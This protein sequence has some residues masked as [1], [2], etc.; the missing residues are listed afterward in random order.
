LVCSHVAQG[1]LDVNSEEAVHGE[2]MIREDVT[3]NGTTVTNPLARVAIKLF[4]GT[5]MIGVGAL[6]FY[7]HY[8]TVS[9]IRAAR[10]W[11]EVPCVIEESEY[12]QGDEGD[13]FLQMTYR[14]EYDGQIYRSDRLDLL[15]GS[16]GDDG[17][18]EDELFETHPAGSES[19]CYVNPRDPNEAV[20]DR[21]HG[22]GGA[23]N[24]RL[25]SFPFLFA[26]GA[27]Y[28]S[29][30]LRWFRSRS[31]A[32]AGVAA[33][34]DP[35]D[36]PPPPRRAGLGMRLAIV[37]GAPGMT[38]LAWAFLVGFVFVFRIMEGP[39]MLR[40]LW[41]SGEFRTQGIVTKVT[42]LETYE[43]EQQ[44]YAFTFEYE[45]DGVSQRRE[46]HAR[47][48]RHDVGDRVE[49]VVDPE[50]PE[51][52]RIEGSRSREVPLWVAL[53]FGAPVPLLAFGVVAGYV[54][55]FRS[56]GL[57]RKG[58]LTHARRVSAASAP[59][60]D[61]A[62]PYANLPKFFFTVDGAQHRVDPRSHVPSN[63]DEVA[64]LYDP[65]NP[66]LNLGLNPHQLAILH[67]GKS[68]WAAAI[69]SLTIPATCISVIAWLLWWA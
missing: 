13:R 15:P 68:A 9:G 41:P 38:Q 62:D 25:L 5:V 57:L 66:A 2:G 60:P 12:V 8:A 44:V 47:G 31:P 11:V 10:D 56:V 1:N 33:G 45:I 64:V 51:T 32:D 63:E 26:G 46:S 3:V 52:A 42:P 69:A 18:W 40:D 19:V 65:G 20:L 39:A 53:L 35:L 34:I 29:E 37:V 28:V 24:V 23:R 50:R 36:L 21:Q 22:A 54:F 49:I 4:L 48:N 58:V 7:V 61:G 17:A 6:L 67:G 30:I 43:F 27:F 16:M 55:N 59:M 14:Y